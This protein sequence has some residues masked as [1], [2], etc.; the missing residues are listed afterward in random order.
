MCDGNSGD[1]LLRDL[2][3]RINSNVCLLCFVIS[4]YVASEFEICQNC[5]ETF[6]RDVQGRIRWGALCLT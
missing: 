5:I 1:I 3:A 4:S 6:G 2:L